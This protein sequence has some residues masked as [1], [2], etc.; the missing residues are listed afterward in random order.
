MST[1]WVS[2]RGFL[3]VTLGVLLRPVGGAFGEARYRHYTA[4][5][6]I[7][8]SLLTFRLPGTVEERVDRVAGR[9]DVKVDGRGSRI[10]NH[11]QATGRLI[12]GRWTPLR[13][14]STFH[15]AGRE[16][17]SEM[18]YDWERRVVEVHSRAET[19]LLRRTRSVEDTLSVPPGRHV[20]DAISALLNYADAQWPATDGRFETWIVR[21]RRTEGEGPDEAQGRYGA[22]LVPFALTVTTDAAGHAEAHIDMTRFSSWA[23]PDRPAR[24][25]FGADRRPAMIASSLILGTSITIRFS[26][27]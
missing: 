11:L 1:R 18:I 8:H 19:F 13:S 16:S 6:D 21:R 10:D 12:D 20:D 23:R 24:M 14:I 9:Y 4:E 22:E 27:A 26:D 5:V 25:V 2:R 7:L 3:T 17:R 15:V